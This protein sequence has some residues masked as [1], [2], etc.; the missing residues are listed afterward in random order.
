MLELNQEQKLAAEHSSSRLLVLAGPGTGKT[1]TLVG[2]YLY[3]LKQGV[4]PE[5]IL[6]CAFS[7]KAA[8]EIRSR[9]NTE[10]GTDL[11]QDNLTTFHALGNRIVRNHSALI[12]LNPPETILSQAFQ[13]VAIIRGIRIEN[14][15]V[16]NETDED[17]EINNTEILSQIDIFRQNLL[18]VEDAGVKASETSDTLL[19]LAARIYPFYEKHLTDNNKIDFERMIQYAIK[20]LDQD[21]KGNKQIV[22]KYEHVLVDEFQDINFSQKRMMDR[23]LEGG[24]KYWVVGDDDQAIYGWRGSDVKFI[25]GFEQ[26][27]PGA[28][29]VNLKQNYRS[30]RSIVYLAKELASYLTSRHDKMLTAVTEAK[31]QARIFDFANEETEASGVVDLIRSRKEAGVNNNEIAVLART[32]QLPAAVA[33]KLALA[34]IPYFTKDGSGLFSD[35]YSK[36]LISAIAISDG[37]NLDRR[38]AIK[39]SNQLESFASN[40]ATNPWPV[41][42]ASLS[43]FLTNRISGSDKLTDDEKLEATEQ[44]KIHKDYLASY[45]G[46]DVVF[47]KLNAFTNATENSDAVYVGT[48]HGAKGLEWNS[49]FIIGWEESVLPHSLAVNRLDEERRL[50]YVGITRAKE[51]LSMSHV[52]K[53]NGKEKVP[54]Q[55]LSD[56]VRRLKEQVQ[57]NQPVEANQRER[58]FGS[59]VV[60]DRKKLIDRVEENRRETVVEFNAAD[61]LLSHEGYSASKNGPT[62]QRR[63]RILQNIFIGDVQIPEFISESV[64]TQWGKPRSQERFDKLR[65]SINSFKSLNEGRKNRSDEAIR[66]WEK[67]IEYLDNVLIKSIES[68]DES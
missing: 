18:D 10:R 22:K 51:Y 34:D 39:I 27:Y 33:A 15:E 61:G 16:L 66:K 19:N 68:N 60:K 26:D 36:Q 6:C 47:E 48:I 55:F 30:G 12:G 43:T 4:E 14:E 2:R 7:R 17:R 52:N 42:V 23:I 11:E 21:A 44:V 32:N 41:K 29:K 54:S 5:K 53:R 25:L 35:K 28:K 46:S 1:S 59:E 58:L 38:Y 50:A 57:P 67:D 20:I 24:A 40:L 49:V 63:Q 62:D 9:I 31:G 3:L 64:L 13:R 56:L 65:N 45:A 37:Q 8:D